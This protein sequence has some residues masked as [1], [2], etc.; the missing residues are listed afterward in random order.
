MCILIIGCAKQNAG[1]A[2]IEQKFAE[3]LSD[4]VYVPAV[5]A[6]EP[7][8][9]YSDLADGTRNWVINA[10]DYGSSV[11]NFSNT[12]QKLT[13]T[14]NRAVEN[15][16]KEQWT[17]SEIIYFNPSSFWNPLTSIDITYTADQPIVIILADSE[18]SVYNPAAGFF[19]ILP[20][21]QTETSLNLVL[22]DKQQFRQHDWVI[23]NFPQIRTVIDATTIIGIKI[24][25][26]AIGGSA[27]ATISR[28][29]L[30][31]VVLN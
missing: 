7:K 22:K 4:P 9:P 28:F 8:S 25:T 19:T 21:S 6:Q 20:P 2:P 10:D 15:P 23:H 30:N 12:A 31:G 3:Q 17:W 11:E 26:T 27:N 24:G 13:F 16:E 18:L 14:L 5:V 29:V 1:V